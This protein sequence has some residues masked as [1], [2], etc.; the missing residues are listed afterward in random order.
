MALLATDAA[1]VPGDVVIV[2]EVPLPVVVVLACLTSAHP[3]TAAPTTRAR[4]RSEIDL[5]RYLFKCA[6]FR[7]VPGLTGEL[8]HALDVRVARRRRD[9][10][11][12]SGGWP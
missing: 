12:G 1:S 4:M 3:D 8:N 7:I 10:A 5:R 9:R 6:A 2:V 11:G